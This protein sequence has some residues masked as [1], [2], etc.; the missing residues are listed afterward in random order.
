MATKRRRGNSGTWEYKITRSKLLPRPVYLTFDSEA[1]GDVYCRRLEQLLDRGIVPPELSKPVRER[2]TRLR[3]VIGEYRDTQAVSKQDTDVIKV[4]LDAEQQR[5]PPAME[6]RE[7]TFQWATEW[8]TGLKREAN[9]SPNRI[10]HYVGAL[11]RCLDWAAARGDM[12]FNPLRLLPRGYATYTAADAEHVQA[13]GG[14]PKEDEHRDRR[15]EQGEELA[16]RAILAG[17]KPKGR[18]R[19]LELHHKEALTALFDL[20][21][22]S[23]MRLSEMYTLDLSQLDFDQRTIFLDRSKNGDRRQVPMT[24]VS[25]RVLREFIGDRTAGRLFPWWSGVRSPEEMK[26]CTSQLSRQY[27]RLFEAAGCEDLGFHDLRHEAISRL[28]ERTNLTD[29]EI[30]RITGHRDPR[31]LKR[32]ANLR[33]SKLAERLW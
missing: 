8:V 12:P 3:H 1:E 18:Q 7:V 5:L 6:L 22:E 4:L 27:T 33:G 16:I 26:R 10:R 23:C 19:A 2:G 20:A 24:T 15:L 14:A 17:G 21:L 11:A 28:F 9:L 30:A 32:Y 13:L 25:E 29:V 31:Q